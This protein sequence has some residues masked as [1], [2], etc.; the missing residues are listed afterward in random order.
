MYQDQDQIE[1]QENF[2]VSY[3]R[4]ARN[5]LLGAALLSIPALLGPLMPTTG[6]LGR[7]HLNRRGHL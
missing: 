5:H 7:Q 6:P 1:G 3:L 2:A 4:C